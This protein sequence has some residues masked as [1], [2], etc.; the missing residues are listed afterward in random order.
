MDTDIL[1]DWLAIFMCNC[2]RQVTVH[3]FR[4]MISSFAI[5][6]SRNQQSLQYCLVFSVAI[7]RTGSCPGVP[8]E[9]TIATTTQV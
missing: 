7:G 6:F 3:S 4:F 2:Q 9:T 5:S 8:P 1:A